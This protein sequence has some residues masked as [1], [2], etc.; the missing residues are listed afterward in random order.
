[1]VH[2]PD[3]ARAFGNLGQYIRHGTTM[4]E[5]LRELAILQVGWLAKNPYKWS[6]HIK[7]GFKFGVKSDDVHKLIVELNGDQTDL[8]R[9]DKLVLWAAR[10]MTLLGKLEGNTLN[11]LN[12][13]LSKK[14][15]TYCLIT[16]SFYNAVV[17]FYPQRKCMLKM[18]TSLI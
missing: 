9:I 8:T 17:F 4:D 18:N 10:E 12:T 11:E 14:H 15:L 6:H 13:H 2:S 5:R 3:G 1:M 16:I 7:I